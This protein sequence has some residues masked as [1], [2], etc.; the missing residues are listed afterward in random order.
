MKTK[1]IVKGIMVMATL[2]IWTISMA[3][4]QQ[5]SRMDR[6]PKEMAKNRVERLD[7][8]LKLDQAQKDTIYK[9]QLAQSEEM[10][11][12]FEGNRDGGDR[13]VMRAKMM[14][15]REKTDKQII[16]ILTEEQQTTYKKIQQ[17]ASQRGNMQRRGDRSGEGRR[18]NR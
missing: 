12:I 11:Q 9:I 17:E 14:E 10:R 13:E 16:S 8:E 18:G 3:T 1:T 2:M 7:K 6:D 5:R 15:M 4:A